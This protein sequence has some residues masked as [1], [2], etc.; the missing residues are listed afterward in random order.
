M[1]MGGGQ[2]R[3]LACIEGSTAAAAADCRWHAAFGGP[4][5]GGLP[6]PFRSLA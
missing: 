1:S 4:A 6:T 3:K 2:A 5:A